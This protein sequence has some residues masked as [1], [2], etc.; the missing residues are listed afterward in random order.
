MMMKLM[1]RSVVIPLT[2]DIAINDGSGQT[3]CLGR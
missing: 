1:I 3:E 2:F